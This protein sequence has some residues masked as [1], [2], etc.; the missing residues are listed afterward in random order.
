MTTDARPASTKRIGIMLDALKNFVHTRDAGALEK[1]LGER[2]E[3]EGGGASIHI[4]NHAPGG[5]DEPPPIEKRIGDL[6][7]GMGEIKDSMAKVTDAVTKFIKGGARDAEEE[8]AEEKEKKKKEKEAADARARDADFGNEE[9]K[10]ILGE[11]RMEAPPGTSDAKLTADSV[12]LADSFQTTIAAAEIIAPGIAVPTF[13]AKQKPGA[14]FDSMCKL[15]RQA[16]DLAYVQPATRSI[17]DQMLAG[18]TLDT[19][20]MT[21]ADTRTLF[22]GV[23]AL[24]RHMNNADNTRGGTIDASSLRPASGPVQSQADLNRVNADF[25]AKRTGRDAA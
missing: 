21:C 5:A 24:K 9:N 18:R 25:W 6:E 16:L 17:I 3:S 10:K 14:T 23:T 4:H 2:D 8:T 19:K 22:A 11:L 20:A 15:R 13:D 1:A 12:P 7:A